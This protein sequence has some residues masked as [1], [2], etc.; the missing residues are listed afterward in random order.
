MIGIDDH[1]LGDELAN[2]RANFV[3]CGHSMF[4]S[5][6]PVRVLGITAA[7]I[8]GLGR[9]LAAAVTTVSR[10]RIDS[11]ARLHQTA[12]EHTGRERP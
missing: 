9:M 4:P 7:V 6:R 12:L 3:E 2:L 10:I 11:V 1:V 5:F 8:Q